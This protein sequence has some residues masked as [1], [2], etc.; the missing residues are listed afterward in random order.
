MNRTWIFTFHRVSV[1]REMQNM[2]ATQMLITIIIIIKNKHDK[3]F[4]RFLFRFVKLLQSAEE[5]VW[6][7]MKSVMTCRRVVADCWVSTLLFIFAYNTF[8][9]Y[10]FFYYFKAQYICQKSSLY[11]NHI[12]SKNI[13]VWWWKVLH[14]I[15][16]L[17]A[18]R[19]RT[20]IMR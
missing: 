12:A 19:N 8:L 9:Y 2:I 10:F 16:F 4:S 5:T 20:I 18:N 15:P 14:K 11:V 6:G 13:L 1:S 17:C 7:C 3:Y